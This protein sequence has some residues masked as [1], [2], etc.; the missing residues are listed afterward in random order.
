MEYYHNILAISGDEFIKYNERVNAGSSNGLVPFD[1]YCTLKRRGKLKVIRPGGQYQ[2]VLIEYQSLPNKY[3]Q[4]VKQIICNGRDPYEV[5]PNSLF[6]NSIKPD[7]MAF[8][9]FSSYEKPDGCKFK[10]N[11]VFQYCD[12]ASIL[13]AVNE[14][15]NNTKAFKKALGGS[16]GEIMQKIADMVN[17][18]DTK[19]YKHEL[20]THYR[21][22]SERLASYRKEGYRGILH[23][24]LGNQNSRKV[25]FQIENLILSLYT[26]PNKPFTNNVHELYLQFLSGVI[27]VVNE[28]TGE[29]YDRNDFYNDKGMPV[30]ISEA[31][32]WNYI[33]DPKNAPKL[34]KLRMNSHEYNSTVRPHHHRSKPMYSLSKIS[35]DDRD[36]PH[37]LINGGT[38]KAYYS[39]DV[40]SGCLIGASYS[41]SKDKTLFIDCM[42]DM[43]R[44]LDK[45]GFG[46]PMEVEV[47]HHL[48][49]NFKDDLMKAGLV[50][51]FVRWCNPGNSQEKHAERFIKDKKYGYEKRYQ[52]GIG[53]FYLKLEANRPKTEKEFTADG[54]FDKVKTFSFERIVADDRQTIEAY[55]NDKH[56]NAKRYPGMTRMDVLK[57]NL[58]PDLANLERP[59]ITRY[60]GE[61]TETC[62][63]R[64]QYVRVQGADYQMES[65]DML[66]MLLPNNYDVDAYYLYEE[67]GDIPCIYLYQKGE[68]I[69]K[70]D[71][72]VKYNTA[73]A[74]QTE[75][76][77]IAY[78][79][80]AKYLSKFDKKVK[81]GKNELAKVSIIQNKT[82]YSKVAVEKVPVIAKQADIEPNDDFYFDDND[83]S[84]SQRA[85]DSL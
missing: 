76:D 1:T 80:Q 36:I 16:T 77:E 31:T 47:E 23:K 9:F 78:T 52:D 75:A 57:Q 72:I 41:I 79:N 3:Q 48:V 49:N 85:F 44:F 50:F 74:E 11:K 39:Y 21:K 32:C 4:L 55:N 2:S 26:M 19:K 12:E 43:F 64:N 60:I 58:N 14:L 28:K 25:T 65:L 37:K 13:N 61:F 7:P 81:D 5:V 20:P 38:V 30:V 45:N 35:M 56:P 24:G 59:I 10:D 63:R 18:L 51:P 68:Y 8:E 22:L 73:K 71:R 34:A 53:R 67:N 42:R 83:E 6:E 15:L 70:C 27:D 66:D 46:M 54:Y 17:K 62:I 84:I 69:G 33:N 40:A 82:D 29:L